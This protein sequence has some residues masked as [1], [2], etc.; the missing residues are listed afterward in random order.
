MLNYFTRSFNT[1]LI[2]YYACHFSLM[3]TDAKMNHCEGR[4]PIQQQNLYTGF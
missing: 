4:C 3:S 1:I 2:F